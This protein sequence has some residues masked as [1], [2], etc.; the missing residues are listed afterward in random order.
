MT[1][2]PTYSPHPLP[3]QGPLSSK[4][5]IDFGVQVGQYVVH[6][7]PTEWM[8]DRIPDQL[9]GPLRRLVAR[10]FKEIGKRALVPEQDLQELMNRKLFMNT[11]DEKGM[12]LMAEVPEDYLQTLFPQGKEHEWPT[13]LVMC[14]KD[15][16]PDPAMLRM[17]M[18]DLPAIAGKVLDTELD[19]VQG[20]GEKT[21]GRVVVIGSY[22]TEQDVLHNAGA[23]L[24]RTQEIKRDALSTHGMSDAAIKA[25]DTLLQL[26]TL[27]QE[28]GETIL[29]SDSA[30]IMRHVMT[31]GYSQGGNIATDI[32]RYVR[33][34]LMSGRYELAQDAQG[35]TTVN[36]ADD[37]IVGNLLGNAYCY[38]IAAADVPYND[39]ELFTLPPRDNSRSDGDLVISAAVGTNRK[40]SNY[41]RHWQQDQPNVGRNDRLLESTA[42][43]KRLF[44]FGEPHGSGYHSMLGH[45]EDSYRESVVAEGGHLLKERLAPRLLGKAVAADISFGNGQTTLAFERGT[46]LKTM[47]QSHKRLRDTLA[48]AGIQS[49]KGN[50]YQLT[51]QAVPNGDTLR[52]LNTALDSCGIMQS[53]DV[54]RVLHTDIVKEWMQRR[55]KK[56]PDA[57]VRVDATDNGPM[58]YVHA[59]GPDMQAGPHV[60]TML[61]RGLERIGIRTERPQNGIA[62]VRLEDALKALK[63]YQKER[64]GEISR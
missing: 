14:A 56:L 9:A 55:L 21:A 15:V 32:F 61:Q 37:K 8:L 17:A 42:P 36:T 22:N 13:Q 50:P 59:T 5:V 28:F 35:Q 47:Q 31:H 57:K 29:R 16:R 60:S 41:A 48:K 43:R 24:E 46:P 62:E 64:G 26:M 33:S 34:E 53:E 18:N 58:L 6:R 38:T 4:G 45:G 20:F 52:A 63:A 51:L 49:D 7:G 39:R 40:Q 10:G 23:V 3:E 1:D 11:F 19:V 25:G 2:T 12:P 44:G 30:D 27:R 54:N